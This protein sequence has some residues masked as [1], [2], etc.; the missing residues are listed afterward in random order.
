MDSKKKVLEI[1]TSKG[2][3]GDIWMRLVSLYSVAKLLP[4]YQIVLKIPSFFLE[5]AQFSF[6]DRLHFVRHFS[7]N[8]S[9]IQYTNLGIKDLLKP[10]LKGN[11]FVSPYQKAVIAD[12]KEKKIKDYINVAI[13]EFLNGFNLVSVPKADLIKCY[14]GFLDIAAIPI[15]RNVSYEKYLSQLELDYSLVYNKLQLGIPIS[16]ELLLPED[17]AKNI[18]VY[19]TGTSR[20][21]VPVWWAVVNL[22][23]AYYAFYFQDDD[24]KAYLEAGLK[25]IY[26]YREPGD[27]IHLAK[28][29]KWTISTDSFPSHL[30]QYS[31]LNTTIVLT[32]VLK[33]RIVSP[34][35]NGIVVDSIAP[36]HPCLHMARKIQPLCAAGY[37]EC[38]N[39]KSEM[40]TESIKKLL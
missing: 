29:A 19:P 20:Q 40:Y 37:S 3:N 12:R 9:V 10:L 13:F 30:L 15:I 33:S 39:W 7:N 31:N 5:L 23:E 24:A 22:P 14:Q 18:L 17:L 21:F 26:F 27:I 36:C 6:G 25:V 8:K 1:D 32:E 2:G 4:E 35:F 16:N 11:R 38:L 34:V 28:N